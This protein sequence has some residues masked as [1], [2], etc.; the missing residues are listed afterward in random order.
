MPADARRPLWP[1]VLVIVTAVG[2]IVCGAL[3]GIVFPVLATA[4]SGEVVETF[5]VER[6]SSRAVPLAP[7]MNPIRLTL[8][9]NYDAPGRRLSGH[10]CTVRAALRRDTV[11]VW[12]LQTGFND[13]RSPGDEDDRFVRAG[14]ERRTVNLGE[15]AVTQAAD[16]ELLT[17]IELD[18]SFTFTSAELEVRRNVEPLEVGRMAEWIVL[19]P[20]G[21][22]M[23][24]LAA[25]GIARR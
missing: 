11:E 5:P 21:I 23:I 12:S 18:D 20:L 7:E 2:A 3:F 10:N 16:H 13:Q 15:I 14:P 9:V 19:I 25:W 1:Y 22:V 24:L 17:E 6:Q 8:T 4:R